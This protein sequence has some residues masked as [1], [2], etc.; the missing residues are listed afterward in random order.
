M[1]LLCSAVSSKVNRI[2][3]YIIL[4]LTAFV[5]SSLFYHQDLFC[6]EAFGATYYNNYYTIL[7]KS[8]SLFGLSVILWIYLKSHQIISIE[9]IILALLSVLGGSIALSSKN[10]IVFFMGLELQSLSSYILA[11]FLRENVKSSESGL[12]YFV[13]GSIS[14]AILL[15]GA[16]FLY[17]FSGQL[18]YAGLK[19]A[20]HDTQNI[21]LVIGAS[22][23]LMSLMF[24]L[25]AAPF[26]FWTP[27]VYEGAPIISVTIFSSIHK[28]MVSGVLVSFLYGILGQL[29]SDFIPIIKS[30]SLLSLA[31]GAFGG[32]LQ[33]SVK[34]LMAYSTILNSGYLL[35]AIIPGLYSGQINNVFFTFYSSLLSK[36][37]SIFY[38]LTILIWS[39]V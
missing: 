36:H 7:F 22:M 25:S 27:D 37:Y 21:A 4:I 13:L 15:L 34:R 16:S 11:G 32:I 17:G 33:N 14:S 39:Q 12:K 1:Y 28:I 3:G 2:G 29:G 8:I 18:D 10:L 38:N 9:F 24:K 23:M 6:G 5:A 31:V 20:L 35:L 30:L 19:I 26:H